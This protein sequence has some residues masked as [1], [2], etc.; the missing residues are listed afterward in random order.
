V[1]ESVETIERRSSLVFNGFSYANGKVTTTATASNNGGSAESIA[2]II[3]FLRAYRQELV[4]SPFNL[5]ELAPV[6]SLD[7]TPEARTFNIDWTINSTKM[8]SL[9]EAGTGTVTQ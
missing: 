8:L 5:F 6:W 7:G 4:S 3:A 1:I 2:R 9:T